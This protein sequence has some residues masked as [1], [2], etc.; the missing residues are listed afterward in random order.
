MATPTIVGDSM[1]NSGLRMVYGTVTLDGSN[2]TNVDLSA[3]LSGA[4]FALAAM[5][6]TGAPGDDPNYVTQNVSGTTL[7]IYAWKN[8]NST[9]P[10]YVAST[11][12]SRVIGFFAVGASA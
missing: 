8:T 6:G 9:D 1:L 3:Y 7:N 12:S 4:M 11:D 2:P 10:T 5:D